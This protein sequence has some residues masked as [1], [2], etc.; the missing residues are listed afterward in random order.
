MPLDETPEQQLERLTMERAAIQQLMAHPS[1]KVFD[2]RLRIGEANYLDYLLASGMDHDK[3]QAMRERVLA[4]REL[5][6]LP[7]FI[8]EEIKRIEK[9]STEG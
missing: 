7:G 8:D 3:T 9:E 4:Y 1:W 2:N 6:N 5:L